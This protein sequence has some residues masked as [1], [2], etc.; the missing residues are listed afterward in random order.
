M[1]SLILTLLICTLA[2]AQ[3]V[4]VPTW[5]INGDTLE[6]VR[7]D[8]II[9]TDSIL[10]SSVGSYVFYGGSG[11]IFLLDTLGSG[12]IEWD[13]DALVIQQDTSLANGDHDMGVFFIEED[14]TEHYII[15]D[16]GNGFFYNG[17]E[18]MRI[19]Q[20]NIGSPVQIKTTGFIVASSYIIDPNS[21]G[22]GTLTLGQSGDEDEV[23]ID[24]QLEVNTT[25]GALLLPR[26]TTAQRDG[27][28]PV[29]GMIIY[30][31]TDDVPQFYGHHSW[32]NF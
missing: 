2:L 4:Y 24:G 25:T 27:L 29:S 12:W 20:L 7:D 11:S 23:V 32:Q 31:T 28:T 22:A 26:L 9:L 3:G 19:G 15:W 21:A 8:M 30:N 6:P 17:D 5:Y 13:G 1:K 14:D 18:T 10:S 16:D